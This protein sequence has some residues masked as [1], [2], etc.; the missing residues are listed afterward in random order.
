MLL[1]F[2]Y[3]P[4]AVA[5]WVSTTP[6]AVG[7]W[8]FQ[9]PGEHSPLLLITINLRVG[10]LTL[11]DFMAIFIINIDTPQDHSLIYL[12]F[13]SNLFLEQELERGRAL[14]LTSL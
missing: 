9:I 12:R 1:G 3:T 13:F 8:G 5:P 4:G 6:G 14:T 2:P 11:L 10:P 7:F